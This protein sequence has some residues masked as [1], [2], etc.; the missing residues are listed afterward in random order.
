M[1]TMVLFALWPYGGQ[2][3]AQQNLGIRQIRK[4]RQL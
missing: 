2:A 1:L 3:Q 4:I